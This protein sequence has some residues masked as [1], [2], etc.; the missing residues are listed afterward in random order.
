MRML[1]F[2]LALITG[3]AFSL[4]GCN[5]SGSDPSAATPS[6]RAQL[7]PLAKQFG[8]YVIKGDWSSAYAMTTPGFQAS[9]PIADMQKQ[10]EDR[11]AELRRSEPTLTL[12][13]VEADV[14]ELP[15]DEAQAARYGVKSVPPQSTWK[16]WMFATLI[17]TDTQGRSIGL[18]TRLFV[19]SD[20]GQDKFAHV[21]F[22]HIN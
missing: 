12:D 4:S 14:G 11:L 22:D 16:A 9:T 13:K 5:A 19:V 3:A 21:Y 1:V 17:G 10:Y 7:D 2:G 8:E 6:T 15:V 20:N 18:E